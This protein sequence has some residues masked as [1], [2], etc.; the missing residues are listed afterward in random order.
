MQLRIVLCV[1]V[2]PVRVNCAVSAYFL[3]ARRRVR[4]AAPYGEVLQQ[5]G[6]KKLTSLLRAGDRVSGGGGDAGDAVLCVPRL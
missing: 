4:D 2:Q 6:A 3:I 1:A 5:E